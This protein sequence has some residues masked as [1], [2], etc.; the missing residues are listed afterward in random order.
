MSTCDIKNLKWCGAMKRSFEAAS[1][2]GLRLV[3]LFNMK[4]GK[5]RHA[6]IYKKDRKSTPIFLNYCPWCGAWLDP[7]GTG[8]KP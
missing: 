5:E 8:K 7:E 6:F 4:T 2:V 3:M 1:G